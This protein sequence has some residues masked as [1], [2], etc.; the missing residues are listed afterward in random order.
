MPLPVVLPRVSTIQEIPHTRETA[1]R[2]AERTRHGPP[3]GT[4]ALLADRAEFNRA[5]GI[6]WPLKR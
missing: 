5:S 6:G 3:V 1:R 2:V 4:K